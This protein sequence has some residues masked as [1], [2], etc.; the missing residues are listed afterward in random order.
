[1]I[2]KKIR[3]ALLCLVCAGVIP[4]TAAAQKTVPIVASATTSA[5]GSVL[6]VS[7]SGFGSAPI[8]TLGSIFLDGVTV[9]SLGTQIT[10]LMPALPLGSYLLTVQSGNS[11]SAAFEMAVGAGEGPEGPQGPPGPPGPA[12][13]AGAQGPQGPAGPAGAAGPAGPQGPAGPAGPQGPEGPQGPMGLT[14]PA[15][16]QGPARV[17]RVPLALPHRPTHRA[18]P[19]NQSTARPRIS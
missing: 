15:G 2:S 3:L 6:F 1:M 13:A 14:G 4:S 19:F 5:D 18:T 10:A 8:V 16:P 9:N 11:K 17:R 12:G 7:G